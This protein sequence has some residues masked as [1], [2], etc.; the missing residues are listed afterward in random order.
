MGDAIARDTLRAPRAHV[1]IGKAPALRGQ[2]PVELHGTKQAVKPRT[3]GQ[4]LFDRG[5]WI[6]SDE[7]VQDDG[8]DWPKLVWVVD[9]R[10]EANPVPIGTFPAPPFEA[11]AKRGGRAR[12]QAEP[13]LQD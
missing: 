1:A 2:R 3:I 12:L 5:L 10:N 4:P 8:A 7:C 11:F 6:V 13:G 9:A